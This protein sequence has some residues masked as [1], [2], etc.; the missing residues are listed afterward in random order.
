MTHIK[1]VSSLL[2]YEDLSDVILVGHSYGGMV[3]TG[4]AATAPERLGCLVYLDAYLPDE[5]QTEEDLWPPELR[6]AAEADEAAGGGVRTPPPSAV[7]GVTDPALAAFMQARVTP[8]PLATYRQPPPAGNAASAALKRVFIHCMAG[9]T[10]PVFA[11]FAA[12]A[13]Q[14]GW[15]VYEM[16][17][18][19]MPMLTMPR[20]LAGLLLDVAGQNG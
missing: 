15:P 13:R 6:R 2:Y 8:H 9:Q 10:T 4:V 18:G 3:I 1:D 5:G 17:S 14:R 16:A 7:M 19:H 12:K 20:E 11:P